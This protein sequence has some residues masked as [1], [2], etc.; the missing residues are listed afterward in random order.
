MKNERIRS[1]RSPRGRKKSG[2]R[3]FR[4]SE[5]PNETWVKC[6]PTAYGL[7]DTEEHGEEVCE[8]PQD[9]DVVDENGCLECPRRS[10]PFPTGRYGRRRIGRQGRSGLS[11]PNQ[12]EL[13]MN[14]IDRDLRNIQN[15]RSKK[16][17][18]RK[19]KRKK[20]LDLFFEDEH[21]VLHE[22]LEIK[23]V[24]QDGDK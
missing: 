12:K 9:Q 5:R 3:R 4:M 24:E 1:P 17:A 21:N 11:V 20:Q 14:E 19:R 23:E 10:C 15:L 7:G 2:S 22:L 13:I 6:G 8:Q 16:Q 18:G